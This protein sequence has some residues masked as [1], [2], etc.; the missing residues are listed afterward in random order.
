MNNLLERITAIRDAGAVRRFHILRTNA[1]QT[2]AEHSYGVAVLV[3]ELQPTA[4]TN[5]LRAALFHDTHERA[6]GDMPS[7]AKWAFPELAKAMHSA[8]SRWNAENGFN[9]EC[10]LT[11]EEKEILHYCDYLELLLWSLEQFNMGNTYASGPA[12]NILQALVQL[13]PPTPYARAV[14]DGIRNV[15]VAT[16]RDRHYEILI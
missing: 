5:L 8:E 13:T 3:C 15:A 16:L 9:Y 14:F 10:T 7:T 12:K 6:T 2:V 11:D 1:Q 4:S